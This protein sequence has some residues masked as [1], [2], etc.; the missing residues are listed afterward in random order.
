MRDTILETAI[1]DT[2]ILP[3][4]TIAPTGGN[5]GLWTVG[6]WGGELLT[7]VG[8]EDGNALLMI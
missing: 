1:L 6:G 8:G 7:T 3:S 2:E 4:L 5:G